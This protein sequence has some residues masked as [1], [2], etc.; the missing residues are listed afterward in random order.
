MFPEVIEKLAESDA[1][2]VAA[3]SATVTNKYPGLRVTRVE[4]EK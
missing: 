2:L 3:I 4:E 1:A